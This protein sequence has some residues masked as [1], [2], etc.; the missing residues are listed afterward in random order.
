MSW[1]TCWETGEGW[2]PTKRFDTRREAL[3]HA[4]AFEKARPGHGLKVTKDIS[5]MIDLKYLIFWR[6]PLTFKLND[7][8]LDVYWGP[9]CVWT[10]LNLRALVTTLLAA[11][12]VTVEET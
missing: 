12:G 1:W 3:N 7:G 10:E 9:E 8:H 4:D 5:K 2:R 6:E 11:R